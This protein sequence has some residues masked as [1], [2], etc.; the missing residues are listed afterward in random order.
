[1]FQEPAIDMMADP[2][3][4]AAGP[5][6]VRSALKVGVDEVRV[7]VPDQVRAAV[8]V[9]ETPPLTVRLYAV[10]VTL[11]VP[12]EA[13]TT[14]VDVAA[15]K[16]PAEVSMLVTVRDAPLAVRT[17]PA[18]T[19]SVTALTAKFEAL[20]SRVVVADPSLTVRVPPT[21]K[22]RVDI[23]NVWAV[24]ALDVNVRLLNS[25]P[26]RLVPAKVIVPPVALVKV[27]VPV[28]A[29]HEALVEALVHVPAT[30]HDSDPKAMY[31]A[32]ADMFT[33]PEV[34]TLP[35]VEVRA[36]PL[37]V[38]ATVE[39]VVVPFA[40]VPPDTVR[41]APTVMFEPIVAV[42]AVTVRL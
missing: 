17:P 22:A 21:L 30:D 19:V 9:V 4:R 7:S 40:N 38:R 12:P 14:I 16:A 39:R 13:F 15:V 11:T 1:V 35:E 26:A 25:L 37:R 27:T 23:V 5:E 10:W 31:E 42:P 32:A 33:L 41:V 18:P 20:V 34:V 2:N 24:A 3:V 29:L 6:E 8:N 28:P 36:P